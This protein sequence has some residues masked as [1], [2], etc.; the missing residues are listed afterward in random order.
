MAN[1]LHLLH[2]FIICSMY[3]LRTCVVVIYSEQV[4]TQLS[5]QFQG[6]AAQMLRVS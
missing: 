4:P 1:V 5:M 3:F 2:K 6:D